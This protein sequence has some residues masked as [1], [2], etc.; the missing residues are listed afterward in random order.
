MNCCRIRRLF[1]DINNLFISIKRMKI[2]ETGIK[3]DKKYVT[4]GWLYPKKVL[5]IVTIPFVLLYFAFFIITFWKLDALISKAGIYGTEFYLY[6]VILAVICTVLLVIFFNRYIGQLK[7]VIY[8]TASPD[9]YCWSFFISRIQLLNSYGIVP[10]YFS[11]SFIRFYKSRLILSHFRNEIEITDVNSCKVC[12]D[13][14]QD[15]DKSIIKSS[16]ILKP[17]YICKNCSDTYEEILSLVFTLPPKYEEFHKI[18]NTRIKEKLLN[19]K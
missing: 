14:I 17:N 9:F 8:G 1:I 13:S 19:N 12:Q 16:N 2:E 6:W 10:V 15:N 18:V 7:N 3:I 5:Q 11:R 4:T